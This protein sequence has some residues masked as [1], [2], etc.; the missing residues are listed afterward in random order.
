M[1][2]LNKTSSAYR[3]ESELRDKSIATMEAEQRTYLLDQMVKLG[4]NTDQVDYI[5]KKQG[6]SR[7][8]TTK[9]DDTDEVLMTLMKS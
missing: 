7:R 9:E 3:L 5:C 4:L 2:G 1:A 6:M 8:C